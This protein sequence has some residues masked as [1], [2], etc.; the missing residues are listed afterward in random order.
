MEPDN[1]WWAENAFYDRRGLFTEDFLPL[2]LKITFCEFFDMIF[3]AYVAEYILRHFQI[4][5]IQPTYAKS[6]WETNFLSS[7]F[8]LRIISGLLQIQCTTLL[9]KMFSS[10]S[11]ESC[12]LE[13]DGKKEIMWRKKNV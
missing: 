7:S 6:T 8:S 12:F 10:R 3:E 2:M 1:V 13:N 5:H 9:I 11:D 4:W